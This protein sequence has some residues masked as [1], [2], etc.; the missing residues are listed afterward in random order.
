MLRRLI[1]ALFMGALCACSNAAPPTATPPTTAPT[2]APPTGAASTN[3][4]ASVDGYAGT[5]WAA[6]AQSFADRIGER[7]TYQCPPDGVNWFIYGTDVYTSDSSVC[8]AAAHMGLIT[9]AEGGVVTI[10]MRPGQDSYVG[11]QRN[12]I[13]SA[14]YGQ[15]EASY[16]FVDSAGVAIVP[17]TQAPPTPSATTAAP[18]VS[19]SPVPG[20]TSAV[21][22]DLLEAGKLTICTPFERVRFAERDAA[23]QPFGV[24]VEIGLAIADQLGLEPVISEVAFEDL[25]DAIRNG[26]CDVTIGGQFITAAR[27]A[28]IDMIPYRQGTQHVVVAAGNPLGIDELADLCGRTVA[29]VEGTIHVDILSDVSDDC[30]AAGREAVE[31]AEYPTEA[32]AEAALSS[33]DAVAYIGNDF[34]TVERP[35]TFELSVALPPLRNGICHRLGAIALDAAVRAALRTIIGDG[36]YD[37]ILEKYDVSHVRLTELP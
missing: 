6:T 30:D 21:D 13:G 4:P 16:V 28:L 17:S 8:T 20:Q 27:L 2:E 25:I 22:A 5:S 1:M 31:A 3:P 11:S 12:G 15:W 9:L 24:D 26:Q 7:L 18:T 29:I 23:G 37:D 35:D 14:Q 36:T 19:P 34:I 32:D 33:G 10:E